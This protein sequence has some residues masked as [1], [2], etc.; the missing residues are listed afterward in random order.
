MFKNHLKIAWRNLIKN[1]V[2]SAINILGL[3][4]GMAVTI[5]IGLWIMDELNV[6]KQYSNHESIGQVYLHQTINDE[7]FSGNAIPRPL[8]FQLREN[9]SDL[10]K[11]IA[12]SSWNDD[13]YL[14][15]GDN[16]LSVRGYHAQHGLIEMLD[17][18]IVAGNQSGWDDPSSIM[19]SE[20]TAQK[21]FGNENPIGKTVI[22]ANVHHLKVS[23]V[24]KDLPKHTRF[25]FMHYVIPWEKYA[26]TQEWVANSID[27]WNNNSFQM[28]V[29]IAENVGFENATSQIADTKM[30]A[31]PESKDN[32]PQFF[33]HKMNDWHLRG[34]YENG[35][36][37]G[38]RIENVW[39]FGI[40]G[41]FVLLLA[42]INFMNLST[43]RSEKRATE[44][45]IRKS[46]GSNRGQ[47]ITQ[48]LSESFLVVALAFVIAVV[49]VI[50]SLGWFNELAE[51][52]MEFPWA[53]PVFWG[54]SILFIVVTALLA[55]SYPALYLSSFKPIK[56][57]KGSLRIGR[58][59]ALPRKILVVTQF[60]VS[61]ALIVS[62]LVVIDQ[63]N[64]S[65]SRPVGYDNTALIQIPTFSSDFFGKYEIARQRFLETDGVV[66]FASSSSP[67]TE[68]WSNRGGYDWNGKPEGFQEDLAYT[69]ISYDYVETMG[70]KIIEGRNFS[71][72]FASDSFAVILNET[73]VKYMGLKDPIGMEIR[74]SVPDPEDDTPNA[75]I[76]GV[77]ED[78]VVQS[79]YEPVKQHMY[80]F[81]TYGNTSYYN[82][83][84]NPEMS[85]SASLDQVGN[86]FKELFP[87]VPYQYD[88]VDEN[89]AAK[90]QSEERFANI[91]KVF[92]ILAII[93]SCL[94][95]FG[96]ASFVAEQRTKEIGVRKVLGA[97]VANLW[98]LLSK[99]FLL[100]VSISIL[101][102]APLAY[103]FMSGWIDRFSY[104][105]DIGIAVFLLAGAGALLLTLI[106]VSFQAIKAAIANPVKSLK[107]E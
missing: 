10:F 84:L 88:F 62:T 53:Q 78:A 43:A 68:V 31:Y 50:I 51:K 59:K 48:F 20:S 36:Q 14:R 3:A 98:L 46:I 55:G 97:S 24:F 99:D 19:L 42:C 64:F 70:M 6:N 71:R 96:L 105:T 29:Q 35:V 1:K 18:E 69:N 82:L 61:I 56:V 63:I 58:N 38:G 75:I 33:L 5:M 15:V 11:H 85:T 95:L 83:R 13:Q 49:L 107:T 4:L 37:I 67:V 2:Y 101:I 40:I 9:H 39:L 7:V 41:I 100:L 17:V 93:I 66:G 77:V 91:A 74:P 102:A 80:A 12:M 25:Q 23:A 94:G 92:T 52:S 60:T 45:G 104:R 21:L 72:Q 28:F 79:P 76:V 8:E 54:I 65:K 27:Q 73:A 22:N 44:V 90:F 32:N 30:K 106:T 103:Y 89:Y 81:D 57:L 16:N 26:N 87:N 86:V 47:L 34:W